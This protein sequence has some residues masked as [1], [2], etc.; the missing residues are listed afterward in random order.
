MVVDIKKLLFN[1]VLTVFLFFCSMGTDVVEKIFMLIFLMLIALNNSTE[2]NNNEDI[3]KTWNY[4]I[5]MLF[6]IIIYYCIQVFALGL[7]SQHAFKSALLFSTIYFSSILFVISRNTFGNIEQYVNIIC[8]VDIILSMIFFYS[9]LKYGYSNNRAAYQM[10]FSKNYLA[11]CMYVSIPILLY[12]FDHGMDFQVRRKSIIS[13]TLGLTVCFLSSS[14]TTLGALIVLAVLYYLP[15]GNITRDSIIKY[16]FRIVAGLIILAIIF[17]I[18]SI[19]ESF[20]RASS[21]FEGGSYI[22]RERLFTWGV[23]AFIRSNKL[24]GT[25]TNRINYIYSYTVPAHNTII[26][27]LLTNGI[28]GLVLF[29]LINISNFVRLARNGTK[30]KRRYLAMVIFVCLLTSLYQPFFTAGYYMFFLLFITIYIVLTNDLPE[31]MEEVK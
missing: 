19:R 9:I 13:I 14:R 22:S 12:Y 27:I 24:L 15:K 28:I 31:E 25:G 3:K 6:I 29:F 26:E 5:T 16:F 8:N 17:S 21:I 18:G 7:S 1:I 2:S 11:A 30:G 4:N 20:Y 23:N 10:G